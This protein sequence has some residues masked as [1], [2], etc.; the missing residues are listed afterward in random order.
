VRKKGDREEI[1]IR[2]HVPPS[3]LEIEGYPDEILDAR[4]FV[5]HIGPGPARI[6]RMRLS[7]IRLR[8]LPRLKKMRE[9]LEP[10]DAP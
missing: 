3:L 1:K 8:D 9:G 5:Q 4:I 2:D 6:A 7:A 10:D